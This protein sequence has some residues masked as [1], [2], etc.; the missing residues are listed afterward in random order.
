MFWL[1][2]VVGMLLVERRMKQPNING[3]GESN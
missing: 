1:G 3:S 2:D